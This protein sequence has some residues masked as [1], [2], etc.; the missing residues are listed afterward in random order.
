[1]ALG[2]FDW[3]P[4]ARYQGISAGF[5]ILTGGVIA[6]FYPD[7]KFA[8]S[9]IAVGLL[10]MA[11]DWPIVPFNMLGP[12]S[13]NLWIRAVVHAAAVFPTILVAP[14]ITGGLCLVFATLT[15]LRA[16]I[17]GEK[18]EPPKQRGKGG[19]SAGAGKDMSA[20]KAPEN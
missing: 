5:F 10:L 1:M 8:I 7:I 2:K 4:W 14:T 16:A 3:Y 17:N 19:R 15:F 6:I 13:S 18:W 20:V 11:W 12:V 9:N